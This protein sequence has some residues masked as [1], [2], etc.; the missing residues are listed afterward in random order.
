[1]MTAKQSFE[2]IASNRKAFRD[3]HVDERLEAGVELRGTEVKAIRNGGVTLTG[4][5]A[6]FEDGD[7]LLSWTAP[8]NDGTSGN[9]TS[10]LYRLK[11]AT[12]AITASNFANPPVPFVSMD[13]ASDTISGETHGKHITGLSPGTTYYFAIITRDNLGNESSWTTA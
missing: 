2:K 7:I 6:R 3:Y 5:Y 11:F 4:G 13:I 12:T 9:I 8:G 10:G 1:M